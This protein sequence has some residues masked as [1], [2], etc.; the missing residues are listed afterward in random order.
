[1]WMVSAAAATHTDEVEQDPERRVTRGRSKEAGMQMTKTRI[2]VSIVLAAIAAAV[3]V[4]VVGAGPAEAAFPG[5]NGKIAFGRGS[6]GSGTL[7]ADIWTIN[8]DG[9][10]AVNL[11]NDG[12]SPFDSEPAFSPDG[13]RIAF[14]RGLG[15]TAEIWTMN[16]DGTNETRLTNDSTQDSQPAFS[17]DGSKIAFT[18]LGELYVMNSDGS[19]PTLLSPQG[20]GIRDHQPAFSPDG[21]KIAFRRDFT[22]GADR[23]ATIRAD[24]TGQADLTDLNDDRTPDWQPLS[25]ELSLRVSDGPDPVKVGQ[26]LTYS[27]AVHNAGPS[28]ATNVSLTDRLPSGV[29]FVS[30]SQGCTNTSGTVRCSLGDVAPGTTTTVEIVVQPTAEGPLSNT[31]SI[32]SVPRDPG[33]ENNSDTEATEVA[34]NR[35]PVANSDAYSVDEDGTLTVNA[36]GLLSDDTDADRD[37]L[38]VADSDSTAP[39]VQPASGPSDGALNLNADGSFSYAPNANFVGTDSFAYR[40]T[41]GTADSSA[42]TVLIRVRDATRPTVLDPVKPTGKRVSPSANVMVTFSE[43]MDQTTLDATTVTLTK[44][45]TTVPVGAAL[46]F[47]SAESVVLDPNKPLRRGATYT[48]TI[49]T[50]AEDLAGNGLESDRVWS[51]RVRP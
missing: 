3:V 20:D 48:A 12:T 27:L 15:T 45:G 19:S 22:S 49:T 50:G 41:D 7:S 18:K 47:P 43:A 4:A 25:F 44:K 42:T 51:F 37:A 36:P 16:S 8:P 34:P 31:A 33:P 9:T 10:G 32:S 17:P 28:I 26:N 13:S 11:T 2:S 40:A 30:A 21:S 24:G 6:T 38:S 39:G 5:Q 1:M 35:T 29:G 23:I 46:R 14:I